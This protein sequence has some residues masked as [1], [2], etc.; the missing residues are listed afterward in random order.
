VLGGMIFKRKSLDLIFAK[1]F[2]ISAPD[3][4]TP[5]A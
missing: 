3:S 1:D 2:K 5:I 4:F